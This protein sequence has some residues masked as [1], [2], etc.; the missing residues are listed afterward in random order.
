MWRVVVGCALLSQLAPAEEAPRPPLREFIGL[1]GHTV[2]FRPELYRPV[3]SKV[4]DYHPLD[5]DI[6]E[7]TNHVPDYPWARNRVNWVSVYRPWVEA[8]FEID[9]CLMIQ[10]IP[11]ESW[12][13]VG[14]D[15]FRIGKAFAAFFGP[16]GEQKLVRSLEIGNEPYPRP[17]GGPSGH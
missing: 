11:P 14:T 15:A 7:E 13:D 10:A 9:A 6:G 8:G 4:R 1:N 3:A 12:R 5:W 2:Q 17:A 16:S